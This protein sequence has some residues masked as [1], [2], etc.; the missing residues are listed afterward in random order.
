[1]AKSA[2]LLL[3][4]VVKLVQAMLALGFF[5]HRDPF[6]TASETI[7]LLATSEQTRRLLAPASPSAGLAANDPVAS[8]AGFFQLCMRSLRPFLPRRAYYE[9]EMWKAALRVNGKRK[10]PSS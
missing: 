7:E 6:N 5:H 9:A 4:Q 1:M 8:A 3:G 10:H 2:P